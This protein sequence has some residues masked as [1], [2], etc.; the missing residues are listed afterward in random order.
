MRSVH[1]ISL[2]NRHPAGHTAKEL[3]V[4]IKLREDAMLELASFD[5]FLGGD[6]H[7]LIF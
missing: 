1:H 4:A 2:I 3:L 6:L 5:L 7:L